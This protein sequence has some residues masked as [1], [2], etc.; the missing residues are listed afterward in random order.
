MD[1]KTKGQ[2]DSLMAGM[3]DELMD[4]WTSGQMD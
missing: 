4:R 2:M 1:G 3:M